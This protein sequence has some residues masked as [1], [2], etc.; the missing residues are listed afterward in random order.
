MDNIAGTKSSLTWATNIAVALLVLAWLIPTVGLFV[1]SFRD[2]DQISA[3]GWWQ[4]PFSV[5]LTFRGRTVSEGMAV[6]DVYVY[7]GNIFQ[8]EEVIE[9][10]G[11]G[12]GTITAF[13]VRGVEPARFP[14]GTVADLGDGESLVVNADGS[15]EYRSPEELGSRGQRVYFAAETPPQFT[16]DNYRTVLSSD[17]MDLAFINTLTVTIPATV[18]PI[19][20]AAF[21]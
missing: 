9:S 17:N 18:I 21:A 3:S 6:D 19:L 10:F 7:T 20:I 2:R 16:L 12:E 11:R 15:Y 1:S 8:D 4:A 14:A 5:E 13:G